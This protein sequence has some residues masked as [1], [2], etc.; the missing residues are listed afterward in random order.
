MRHLF[1][2]VVSTCLFLGGCM[3][4]PVP[5]TNF[6]VADWQKQ[7]ISDPQYTLWTGDTIAISVRTA[8]ELSRD[9]IIIAPDGRVRFQY[10][11]SV[12]AAGQTIEALEASLTE[13]LAS[14]L[15]DPRVFVSATAF[16]SQQIFVSGEV[17]A[18][19]ILP[20]PGQIGPI[21]AI[22]MAGG[23][24]T[25]ANAKQVILMRRTPGG[26]VRSA[27]YNVKRGVLDPNAANWGPLQRFDVVHVSRTWIAE[28]NLFVRQYIRDALPVD[29]TLFF[30]VAGS[31]L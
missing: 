24:T 8:P 22:T 15:R 21:E 27:V 25:S 1:T 5:S 2:A 13:A 11:G 23:F 30:D 3:N 17:T 20:L 18:P 19:G 12:Q 4:K 29:F 10:A 26:E 31:G 14:E 28:E 9:D 16:G 6:P 7:D